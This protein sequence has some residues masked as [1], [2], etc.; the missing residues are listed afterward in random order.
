M[1]YQTFFNLPE[2][3]HQRLM[4]AVWQEFTTVSY[5]EASINKIIQA[6]GIS[7][8]S[9]YQYFA[10]KQDLFSY[11]LTTVYTAGKQMFTAQLTAHNNNLFSAIL[12]MYDMIL[13]KK[14]KGRF[15][16][17]QRKIHCLIRL[18]FDMDLTQFLAYMDID[19]MARS[20]REV[21]RQSGYMVENLE[22]CY[23]LLNMLAAVAISGLAETMRHP[24]NEQR[25]RRY[26]EHQLL[27]IRRGLTTYQ[28]E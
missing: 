7:R 10:G 16:D 8:G 9:F 1:P 18:N 21:L 13:W 28:S 6:A 3:K 26:L 17:E 15:T 22:E 2:V 27:I 25:N 11:L 23:A 12:G 14:Q 24:P 4:D 19:S 5:N 20:I